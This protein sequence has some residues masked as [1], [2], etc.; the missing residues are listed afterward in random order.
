MIRLPQ[1]LDA[2]LHPAAPLRPVSCRV[3]DNLTP[4]SMAYITLGDM[5]DLRL[6]DFV[7]IYTDDGESVY[8][9]TNIRTDAGG[10]SDLTLQHGLCTLSDHMHPGESTKTGS[11]R[12][13]LTELLSNQSRWTLGDVAVPDSEQVT[14]ECSNTNDL[15]D[16]LT[17]MKALPDYYID[18]DQRVI[19]WRLHIRAKPTSV[20]CEARF[21]RNLSDVQIEYDSTELCTQVYAEGLSSPVD[22]DTISIWGTISRY[23]S[24]DVDRYLENHKNPKATITVTALALS[25]LTGE[26]LDHFRKGM[27]CRCILPE[28]TVV[29]RIESLEQPDLLGAPEHVVLTLANTREDLSTTV[30]GLVSG[31]VQTGQIAEQGKQIAQ[32]AQQLAQQ[33]EKNLK[34][35][36]ETIEM[37]AQEITLTATKTEVDILS[38]RIAVAEINMNE[39]F[40]QL[41]MKVTYTDFETELNEV[42]VLL[43]SLNAQLTLKASHTDLESTYNEVYLQLDAMNNTIAAKADLILLD[44]YVKTSELESKVLTILEYGWANDLDVQSLVAGSV[45][46][47]YLSSD[48]ITTDSLSTSSLSVGGSTLTRSS[49][50]FITSVSVLEDS[51]GIYGIKTDSDVIYY[52]T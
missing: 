38:E 46:T 27:L 14:W 35:E 16:L 4:L 15:Q 31:G 7:R 52:Y 48:S 44:G 18:C 9:V 32:Q 19:P 13:L 24:V 42:G 6:R 12:T 23:V 5:G 3:I 45:N 11:L 29:Q 21:D 22:A 8:R 50:R 37:L 26:P 28:M 2:S 41:E 25:R 51:D 33:N 40:G 36:A 49:K 30:A 1:L 39:V 10:V 47:S 34:F 43:D 20:G 17:I